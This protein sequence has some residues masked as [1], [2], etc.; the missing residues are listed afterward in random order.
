LLDRALLEPA[1]GDRRLVHREEEW[2]AG[3]GHRDG[4]SIRGNRRPPSRW[5]ARGRRWTFCMRS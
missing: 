5:R 1:D 2:R 4:F 3:I